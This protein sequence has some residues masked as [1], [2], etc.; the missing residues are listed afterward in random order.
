MGMM[1][2]RKWQHM[3]RRDTDMALGCLL[4]GLWGYRMKAKQDEMMKAYGA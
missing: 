1:M 2:R 3:A 4:V